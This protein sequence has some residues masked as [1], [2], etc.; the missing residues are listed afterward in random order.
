MMLVKLRDSDDSLIFVNPFAVQTITKE[1]ET[2][3]RIAF[4]IGEYSEI[5]VKGDVE[6]VAQKFN[7]EL[8]KLSINNVGTLT[9]N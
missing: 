6:T 3:S 1:N 8:N 7:Y 4:C 5:V 9:I 2:E